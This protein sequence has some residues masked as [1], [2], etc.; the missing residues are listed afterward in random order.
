MPVPFRCP[1]CSKVGDLPDS[2]VGK[3]V[4]CKSCRSIF[5]VTAPPE[6][7]D[8]TLAVPEPPP[9]LPDHVANPLTACAACGQPIAKEAATC[10]RCGAPNKWVHPEIV[11]FYGSIAIFKFEPATRIFHDKFALMGVD[12]DADRGARSVTDMTNGLWVIGDIGTVLAAQAAGRW[13]NEWARKKRK[14][15]KID[16]TSAPPVWSST[17]DDWWLDVMRFFAVRRRKKRRQESAK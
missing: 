5:V 16:F 17:D 3:R 6:V 15:F 12:D 14:A 8:A 2:L 11:R 7:I 9:P 10:P 1:T 13:I 4:R